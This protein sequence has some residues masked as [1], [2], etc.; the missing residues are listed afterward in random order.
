M[1]STTI[2]INELEERILTG[3]LRA[4]RRKVKGHKLIDKFLGKLT[5]ARR[6]MK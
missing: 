4:Y 5:N 6:Q 2:R 3:L 1:T